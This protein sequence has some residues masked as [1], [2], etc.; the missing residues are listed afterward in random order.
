MNY[1]FVVTGAITLAVVFIRAFDLFPKQY[2]AIIYCFDVDGTL[3][4][5]PGEHPRSLFYRYKEED[6]AC[7]KDQKWVTDELMGGSPTIIHKITDLMSEIIQS[8]NKIVLLTNNFQEPVQ[9]LWTQVYGLP[10]KWLS[11]HSAF[12]DSSKNKM[13][14][15]NTL[16]HK[17]PSAQIIYFEDDVGNF[18]SKIHPRLSIIDCSQ[19]QWLDKKL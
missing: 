6:L 13:A 5:L 3:T 10:L 17:Y 19:G 2:N 15:I 18:P 14:A 1:L 4:A 11:P 12:R 9:T 8:Q 7:F 16:L